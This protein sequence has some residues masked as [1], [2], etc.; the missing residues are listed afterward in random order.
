MLRQATVKLASMNPAP[1]NVNRVAPLRVDTTNTHA[2]VTQ[3]AN[4]GVSVCWAHRL[5][6]ERARSR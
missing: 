1:Y 4:N 6:G 5:R 3:H 2:C